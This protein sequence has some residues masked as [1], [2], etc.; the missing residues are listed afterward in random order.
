MESLQKPLQVQ[1]LAI[2]DLPPEL[3][4]NILSRLSVKSL[5]RFRCVSKLWLALI[6][7]PRF[8]KMHLDQTQREKLFMYAADYFYSKKS[9]YSVNFESISYDVNKVDAVK[10]DI[11]AFI[12]DLDIAAFELDLL[13]KWYTWFLI[14][15]SN[16]LLCFG[17]GKY[18]WLY[19][20]STRE[21]KQVPDFQFPEN[22][23]VGFGFGFSYVDSIDDYKFVILHRPGNIVDIYSLRKNS[24]TSIQHDFCIRYGL[25]REMGFPLNGAIHW[26]SHYVDN[27]FK[28]D[29]YDRVIIAFDL[30]EENFKTLH[31]PIKESGQCFGIF[32]G[33]LSW[34]DKKIDTYELWVM[35]EYG[36]IASWTRILTVNSSCAL[37]PL[38]Y[39]KN[40][41]TM[42][43]NRYCSYYQEL[44]FYN[45][46][47]R[48]FKKI[49]VNGSRE[50][51][52]DRH[53]EYVESLVSLNYENHFRTEDKLL[54]YWF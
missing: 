37:R 53:I 2:A 39:L 24:W 22:M 11:A 18:F 25:F 26:D 31:L 9:F 28:P 34:L 16:G 29:T 43:L 6:N 14:G 42:M 33:Y 35:K 8:V 1:N 41:N 46:K 52:V 50:F 17:L 5:C 7:H 13:V 27:D 49:E 47:S 23:E 44:V 38:C 51:Y 36:V 4:I 20:P 32:K 48:K 21:R 40:S 30:V 15:S 19:N 54:E 45:P 12:S 10:M 3:I